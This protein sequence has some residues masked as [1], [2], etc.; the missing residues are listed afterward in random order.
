MTSLRFYLLLALWRVLD[1]CFMLLPRRRPRGEVLAGCK[2]ISHRGEHDNRNVRENTMAAFAAVAAA[3]VWGIEFDLRWTRDLHPVVIHDTDTRRVFGV[4]LVVSEVS[5]EHLKRRVPEVPT[6]AEVVAEF[7]GVVHLMVE[8]KADRLGEYAARATRLSRIF[9]GLEAVDDFHFLTLQPDML[10]LAEFAGNEACLL[11]AELN[12]RKLSREVSSRNLGG[13]CGHYLLLSNRLQRLHCARGQ[14]VGT[15]FASSRF[16]FY[17]EL[18][19]GV[20]WIFSNHACKLES[21][22]TRLLRR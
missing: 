8:I 10:R 22:R 18:N 11:V 9:A 1:L 7:G 21:I 4:D 15:G 16:C 5:L 17:R 3:Q 12:T 19:R 6:L 2:I 14:K 13:L 20:D